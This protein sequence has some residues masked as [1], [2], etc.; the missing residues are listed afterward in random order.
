MKSKIV[1]VKSFY[2]YL[3]YHLSAITEFQIF[4]GHPNVHMS[5]KNKNF[6]NLE[7]LRVSMD[8]F[9][10]FFENIELFRF[11][12]IPWINT[13]KL[14]YMYVVPICY[15][16]GFINPPSPCDAPIKYSYFLEFLT[17]Q[18]LYICTKE[19]ISKKTRTVVGNYWET[20]RSNSKNDF[21][22]L[23]KLFFQVFGWWN[24]SRREC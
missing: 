18:N 11:F 21:L 9:K 13:R 19:Y 15:N 6:D 2:N 12:K 10:R 1:K 20:S 24:S 14:T 23:K 5:G 3:T 7:V 8:D 4:L 22:F 16:R 17:W